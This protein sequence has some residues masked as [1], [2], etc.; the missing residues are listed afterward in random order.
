MK[1]LKLTST[2]KYQRENGSNFVTFSDYL[3]L[4]TKE[5][6]SKDLSMDQ[7]FKTDSEIYAEATKKAEELVE[8]YDQDILND[9][10]KYFK[11]ITI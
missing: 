5:N 10:T 7:S 2:Y 4:E 8:K 3:T 1:D 9:N 6:L 11:K